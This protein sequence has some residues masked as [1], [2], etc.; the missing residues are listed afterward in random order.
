ADCTWKVSGT[1]KVQSK[2]SELIN[3]FGAQIPLKG[4]QVKISGATIGWFDEWGTVRTGADGKFS[5]TKQKS[6]EDRK[7]KIEVKFQSDDVEIRHEHSTSDPFTNVKWY[8]IIQDSERRR[9]PGTIQIL[10]TVFDSGKNHDLSDSEARAHA[11][12][13]VMANTMR[14]R[15]AGY[16]SQFAFKKQTVIKYPHNSAVIGDGQEASYTNPITGVTYIFKSN[17][18]AEDHLNVRTVYHE[19]AH[20]WQ[21]EHTS[22]ELDLATN[23]IFTGSTHC[24][25]EKEHISFLE[26]HAEFTMERLYEEIFGQKHT[27]PYN[28]DALKEGLQCEGQV[29]R[30]NSLRDMEV[31]EY[32]WISLFRMLTTRDL[33]KYTYAGEAGSSNPDPYSSSNSSVFITLSQNTLPFGC[34]NPTTFTLKN[35]LNVF[36]PHSSKGYSDNLKKSEM[37]IDDFMRRAAKILG[38][39]DHEA[40]LKNLLDPAKT[41]EPRDELCGQLKATP[42]SKPASLHTTTIINRKEK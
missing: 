9:Q 29:D 19:M 8:T 38:F 3:K 25:N 35:I 15:L 6:C 20:K 36:L 22:G 40:A 37:N 39:E 41:S 5:L 18:G 27:L 30:I 32:G 21:Y 13:W 24:A 17:D 33:F 14:D 26:A 31:H 1:V 42:M 12:I 4:I 11:D 34:A 16:G 2:E 23:L 10:P 7:L 28:R